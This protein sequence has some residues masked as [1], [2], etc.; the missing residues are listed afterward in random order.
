MWQ[1]MQ[2]NESFITRSIFQKKN[3]FILVAEK[4]LQLIKAHEI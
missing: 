2:F 1:K 4:L 3:S